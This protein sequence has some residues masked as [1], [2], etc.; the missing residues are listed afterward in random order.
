MS[1]KTFVSLGLL[2]LTLVAAD[3]A[4]AARAKDAVEACKLA[5]TAE[6]GEE[7]VAKLIK[8]KSRGANY[9]VWLNVKGGETQQRSYC[10]LRRGE[11]D[12]VVVEDGK[13]VGRNPRRPEA[14]QIG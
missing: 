8:V 5:A 9:E 11:V 13:W 4:M 3:G 14:I 12:Q 1:R 2:A 7:V 6:A 10:Y